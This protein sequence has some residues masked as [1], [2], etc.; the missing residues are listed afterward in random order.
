MSLSTKPQIGLW[1]DCSSNQRKCVVFVINTFL[2]VQH[3][4]AKTTK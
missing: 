1:T 3:R 2:T 4:A